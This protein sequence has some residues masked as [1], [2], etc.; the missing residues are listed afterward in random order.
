MNSQ[1]ITNIAPSV[2]IDKKLCN[3]KIINFN[4]R[5]FFY[6]NQKTGIKTY[7]SWCAE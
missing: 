7:V 6:E 2:E 1:K 3:D 5:C 4:R